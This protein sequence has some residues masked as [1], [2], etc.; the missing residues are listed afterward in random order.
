MV[1]HGG[2][3]AYAIVG[4]HV[5]TAAEL[6]HPDGLVF[7]SIGNLYIADYLNNVVRK[8]TP[9]GMISTY[10]GNSSLGLHYSGDGGPATAAAFYNLS[11]MAI[12]ATGNL[13][14]SD[15]DNNVIRKVNTA[16]IISTY[17]GNGYGAGSVGG[18]TG[19]GGQATAAELS[20]PNGLIFDT[21]GNL[22][23]ADAAN[24]V[25]RKVDPSGVISTFAGTGTAGYSGDGGQATS[26]KLNIPYGLAVDHIGNIYVSD[27]GNN[28]IRKVDGSGVIKTIAG[29]HIQG[30]YGD[31]GPATA[32]EFYWPVG[33]AFDQSGDLY[34]GD[35]NNH[36]V[37]K[38]NTSGMISTFAGN[39]FGGVGVGAYS[40]DGGS[41]TSA[42]LS[43]PMNLAF[44]QCGNLYIS[45]IYNNVVRKVGNCQATTYENT[46]NNDKSGDL[47]VFP[48]PSD[49]SFTI[50]VSEAE[51][52]AT[53]TI[54]DITGRTVE[55]KYGDAVKLQ[56]QI[57]NINN[58]PTGAYIVKVNVSGKILREKVIV[59]TQ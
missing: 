49:G 54:I 16:G 55:T 18:Y 1:L 6:W 38:I 44:D 35:E 52:A 58:L 4:M 56:K 13:Y 42:E 25:V 5:A 51:G 57:F 53:V 20:S 32:A 2:A 36:V 28:V 46:V 26:A 37:R 17:A 22:Y 23:I 15:V 24:N 47:K 33:L 40:G 34:V 43:D 9:A 14:I 39:G 48:N 3:G 11:G 30:Y 19:D 21:L 31:G 10:A 45:D 8:V 12:D 59:T 7:D 50:E 29:N 27:Q 41:A